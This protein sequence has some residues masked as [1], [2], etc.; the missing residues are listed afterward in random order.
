MLVVAGGDA[1]V[2]R[3]QRGA[4]RMGRHVQPAAVE[5]EADGRGRLP[6]RTPPARRRETRGPRSTCPAAAGS[7]GSPPPA[8]PTARAGRPAPGRRSPSV[9][10]ARS[11][12]AGRRRGIPDSPGPRPARA[13]ARTSFPAAAGR[14]EI[15]VLAGPAA[16]PAGPARRCG[17]A[18]R[19]GAAAASPCLSTRRFKR[20]IVTAASRVGIAASGL[21]A[22]WPTSA[23]NCGSVQRLVEQAGD[24][25]ELLG[26]IV[27][28]GRRQ[29]RP[30]VPA[31]GRLDRGP[32]GR[33]PGVLA[34]TIVKRIQAEPP[35]KRS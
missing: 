25:R 14:G 35:L 16:R 11:R 4:K 3:A 2:V 13:S 10:P 19:P 5:I 26:P 23:T 22:S 1:A 21:S 17:S 20:R 9:P 28:G 34:D 18:P 29:L 32:E 12:P 31:Q 8:A 24:G 15:V 6:G 30:L 27:A 7:G 33:L